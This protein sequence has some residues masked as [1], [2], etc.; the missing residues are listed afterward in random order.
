MEVPERDVSAEMLHSLWK[1]TRRVPGERGQERGRNLQIFCM[2]LT[3]EALGYV[4][5]HKINGTFP[6]FSGTWGREEARLRE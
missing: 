5:I 6:Q 1:I 3:I 4:E 2:Y